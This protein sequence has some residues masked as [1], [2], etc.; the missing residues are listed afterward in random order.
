[1]TDQ[2][3]SHHCCYKL[4]TVVGHLHSRGF[5]RLRIFPYARGMWWRC[6]LAPGALFDPENGAAFEPHPS[7]DREGLV[8]RFSS[9]GGCHPFGWKR[10][11]SRMS[12]G[13]ISDMFLESFPSIAK[14]SLGPDWCYAGWY[15]EMLSRTSPCVLPMAYYRDEYEQEVFRR[16][17]LVP[18]D[19]SDSG[20][21]RT[22]MPL[23]PTYPNAEQATVRLTPLPR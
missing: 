19:P 12:V 5:Q 23:P 8:A 14:A 18:V 15:Q 10:N 1:M 3:L 16:L 22:E 17:V 6:E 4:L 13:K 9:G 21:T 20:P 7:H 2:E 11:I